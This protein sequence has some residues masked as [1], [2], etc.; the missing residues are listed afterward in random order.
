MTHESPWALSSHILN[1]VNE[2]TKWDLLGPL[3]LPQ[4]KPQVRVGTGDDGVRHTCLMVEKQSL[5]PRTS[6]P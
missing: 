6:S 3:T 4:E 2:A 1:L 5:P